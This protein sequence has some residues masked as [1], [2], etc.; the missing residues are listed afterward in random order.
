MQR[1]EFSRRVDSREC[2][3]QVWCCFIPGPTREK[4]FR[5]GCRGLSLNVFPVHLAYFGSRQG[6]ECHRAARCQPEPNDMHW[7]LQEEDG[8]LPF[9]GGMLTSVQ[10]KI[11]LPGLSGL[12]PVALKSG[13]QSLEPDSTNPW[14]GS[15]T[16]DAPATHQPDNFE[17]LP[18][19]ASGFSSLKQEER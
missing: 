14:E 4:K 12:R 18:F 2:K 19:L 11:P 5:K 17:W 16:P 15:W 1:Q 8:S 10:H 3:F 9:L 13:K 7:K 6:I